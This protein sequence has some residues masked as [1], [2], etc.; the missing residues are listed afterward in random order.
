MNIPRVPDIHIRFLS[1]TGTG[2]NLSLP[3]MP[4]IALVLL[5]L[6][7]WSDHG[8][9][10][11][12]FERAKVQ[13]D[14][15]DVREMLGIARVAQVKAGDVDSEW[16]LEWISKRMKERVAEHVK[17]FPECRLSWAALGL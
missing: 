4:L 1:T 17:K 7:A 13:Q 6:Q 8:R 15:V 14:V 12:D 11:K 2:G 9:S 16:M 3:V 5:K 10:K